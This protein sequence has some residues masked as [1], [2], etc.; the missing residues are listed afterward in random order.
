MR[1]QSKQA[2]TSEQHVLK[3]RVVLVGPSNRDCQVM[4]SSVACPRN[5]LN[6]HTQSP[7]FGNLPIS[8]GVRS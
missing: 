2:G 3:I 1:Q 7:R 4:G 5:Q 6:L 8:N